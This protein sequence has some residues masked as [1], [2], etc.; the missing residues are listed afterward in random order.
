MSVETNS[1]SGNQ[2]QL[3]VTFDYEL[4]LGNRSGSVDECMIAPTNKLIVLLEKYNVSAIFFVDTTYL[5]RLRKQA[6]STPACADDYKRISDQLCLLV[7]K[8]HFVYPHLHPHWLDAEYLPESNQ[9]RLNNTQKYL[10]KNISEKD[11]LLVFDGSVSLLKDVLHPEFPD[12]KIN[13]FRA[14]G[15]SI[16]PFTDFKQYFEKHMFIYEFSV[17]RG[18]YQFTD[19][20]FFDFSSAPSKSI[21][22]F[23]DD[24]C[25]EDKKG[26]YLQFNISSIYIPPATGWLNKIWMKLYMKI[27]NDHTFNK[28]EGQPSRI[29]SHI[30]PSSPEGKDLASSHW[31]RVA[32]ELL[33]QVKLRKYLH[34]IK[35]NDY[36]HFI[37]H[38]KMI[39]DHNLAVLDK[40]LKKAFN[41][42][43]IV[44]NFQMMI[45]Q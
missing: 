13:A 44:T 11:R 35:L 4:F 9:W 22:R 18:F 1:L 36:M 15:W 17:L 20:Q 7:R 42:Y 5:L 43:Q 19:A 21:Y 33:T 25:V 10:F 45:P 3:L 2:K 39:T 14:G 34:F 32:V 23:S 12:Y 16:Q 37:S 24:V 41:K 29:V 27:T 8:G 26:P 40:F 30:N 31:E 38:P 6:E 28:G